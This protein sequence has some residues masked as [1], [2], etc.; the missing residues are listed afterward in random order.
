MNYL[1]QL[2][3]LFFGLALRQRIGLCVAAVA[4]FGGIIWFRDY[5]SEQNFKPLFQHLSSED[6]GIIVTRLKETGTEGRLAENGNTIKS[7]AEKVDE[8]CIQN[9]TIGPSKAGPR[10]L[11]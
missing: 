2:R 7:S 6:A 8:L 11:D 5:H 1:R 4:V 9:A 3:D 10:R